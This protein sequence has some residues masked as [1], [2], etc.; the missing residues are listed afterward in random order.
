[1][2]VDDRSASLPT[3]SRANALVDAELYSGIRVTSLRVFVVREAAVVHVF[4]GF[5]V[6]GW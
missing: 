4:G 1:V 6:E 3:S 2:I 5:M